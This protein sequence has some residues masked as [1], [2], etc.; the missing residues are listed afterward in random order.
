M[1]KHISS[2]ILLVITM[3]LVARDAYAQQRLL[4]AKSV[5]ADDEFQ[6][7][8]SGV[9]EVAP[10]LFYTIPRETHNCK[11]TYSFEAAT[12]EPNPQLLILSYFIRV[13]EF[14]TP[15]SCAF[16]DGPILTEVRSGLDETHTI[17]SQTLLDPI[18]TSQVFHRRILPCV[19]SALGGQ[20]RLR[21]RCLAVECYSTEP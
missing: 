7:R 4:V 20:F 2:L 5:C 18:T 10:S 21:R 1:F 17:I 16:Q 12:S 11:L 6:V 3:S 13:E 14:A 19:Q 15:T 8:E 9:L